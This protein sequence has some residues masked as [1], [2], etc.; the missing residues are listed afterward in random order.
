MEINKCYFHV[1]MPWQ[2]QGLPRLL[3][4]TGHQ[5][6]NNW[7]RDKKGRSGEFAHTICSSDRTIS[8]PNYFEKLSWTA[9]WFYNRRHCKWSDQNNLTGTGF[10]IDSTASGVT[11]IHHLR[12][13]AEK[14]CVNFSAGFNQKKTLSIPAY[15][16][17]FIHVW[18]TDE[19]SRTLHF[20]A[21][22]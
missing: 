14:D 6:W 7:N 16:R 4:L 9:T 10:I 8:L 19:I 17:F 5:W 12:S 20:D 1:L 22:W 18:K 11:N 13:T 3:N 21:W 2:F 15:C